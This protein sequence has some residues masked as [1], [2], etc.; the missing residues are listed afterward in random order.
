MIGCFVCFV[1]RITAMSAVS[2]CL[3]AIEALHGDAAIDLRGTTNACTSLHS[4]MLSIALDL[5]EALS[6]DN[7][8]ELSVKIA[9][10][11]QKT[12]ARLT[13]LDLSCT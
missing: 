6:L 12:L 4:S 10:I 2:A 3:R 1:R 5:G 13:V 9:A 11:P 8:D 7:L